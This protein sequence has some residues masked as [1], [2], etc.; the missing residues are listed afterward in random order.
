MAKLILSQSANGRAIDCTS[1]ISG[2]SNYAED[3]VDTSKMIVLLH[4]PAVPAAGQPFVPEE[5]FLTLHNPDKKSMFC[6]VD[7]NGEGLEYKIKGN[8][9]TD[10]KLTVQGYDS[11]A[12]VSIHKDKDVPLLVSG[13]AEN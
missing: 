2:N 4:K 5:V 1:I 13:G 11:T 7:F 6:R 9:H 10:V 3:S 12:V 8:S